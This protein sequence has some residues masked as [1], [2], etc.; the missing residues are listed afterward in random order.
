MDLDKN[1]GYRV[2]ITVWLNKTWSFDMVQSP[3][4]L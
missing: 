3:L 1:K 4:N 2:I